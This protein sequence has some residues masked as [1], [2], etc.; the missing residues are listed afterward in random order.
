MSYPESEFLQLSGLQHFCFCRRQW[1]LIHIEQLWAENYLTA[2]GSIMH[3]KTHDSFSHEVRG[4]LMIV[5]GVYIHSAELGVSGQCDVLEFHRASD[6][7]ILSGREGKWV[8]FPV[9]YKSGIAKTYDADRL[10]LCAQA[11]CLEKMLCC[12]V[13]RGALFYGQTRRRENVDFSQELRNKVISMLKEMH[14]LFRKGYTP[15]VKKHKGC[16][17]CSLNGLC[18]PGITHGLSVSGYLKKSLED[19][20]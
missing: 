16:T 15:V 2:D 4:D 20:G 7:I 17:A 12:D 11:M 14:E 10:Q 3:E 13:P 19:D 18:L 8:P 6:G 1:A 9:E 5:R